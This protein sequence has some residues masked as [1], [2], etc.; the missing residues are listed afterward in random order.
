MPEVL[1]LVV[2]FSTCAVSMLGGVIPYA[3]LALI[4]AK[5][6]RV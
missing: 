5:S 1:M 6:G 4:L 2:G 3:A